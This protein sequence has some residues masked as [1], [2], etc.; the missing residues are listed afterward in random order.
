MKLCSE[1]KSIV[2]SVIWA[3]LQVHTLKLSG[4]GA[5]LKSNN[6]IYS[7]YVYQQRFTGLFRQSVEQETQERECSLITTQ[8]CC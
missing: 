4:L 6:Y 8:F 3:T 1:T 5:F 2:S 7:C